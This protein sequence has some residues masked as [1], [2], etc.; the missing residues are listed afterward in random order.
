MLD[1]GLAHEAACGPIVAGTM[2]MLYSLQLDDPSDAARVLRDA[3]TL[4]KDELAGFYQVLPLIPAAK[5][6]VKTGKDELAARLLGAYLHH[7]DEEV[8]H[9]YVSEGRWCEQLVD[10]L[11]ETLG[12]AALDE[13]FHHGAQFSPAQALQIAGELVDATA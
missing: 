1:K 10:E 6:A 5:I 11:S 4:A 13:E 3:I 8:P 9:G 12:P 2:R 7:R